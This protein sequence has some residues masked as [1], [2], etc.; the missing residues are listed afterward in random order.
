MNTR[1]GEPPRSLVLSQEEMLTFRLT[2]WGSPAIKRG[3]HIATRCSRLFLLP[4]S[5]EKPQRLSPTP[6]AGLLLE[7]NKPIAA[8][9]L[10]NVASPAR[11]HWCA[12]RRQR[13][14]GKRKH[15]RGQEGTGVSMKWVKGQETVQKSHCTAAPG[16]LGLGGWRIFSYS[17][18]T[19]T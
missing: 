8:S 10:C 16:L 18:R 9:S 4:F 14:K 2:A 13:G 1:R 6:E 17:S 15:K 3:Y 19:G 12:S 5:L 7:L 11:G